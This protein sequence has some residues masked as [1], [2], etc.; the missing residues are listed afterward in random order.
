MADPGKGL[1]DHL[2]RRFFDKRTTQTG[3]DFQQSPVANVPPAKKTFGERLAW[4]TV[5]GNRRK[6]IMAE[7]DR[8]Q[9]EIVGM[10][11]ALP[12]EAGSAMTPRVPPD[13][14]ES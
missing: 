5:R 4:W 3:Y 12:R 8:V 2:Y 1:Y 14:R 10:K 6:Q 13:T 9:R 11:A 7:R